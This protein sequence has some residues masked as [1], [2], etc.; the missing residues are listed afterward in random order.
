MLS[1]YDLFTCIW[2]CTIIWS[3]DNKNIRVRQNSANCDGI[4][5]PGKITDRHANS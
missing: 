4:H 5:V 2:M 1:D 3:I